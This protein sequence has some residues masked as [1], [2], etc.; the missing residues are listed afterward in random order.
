M[1]RR[2]SVFIIFL[3]FPPLVQGAGE[4]KVDPQTGQV[5]VLFMGDALMEAGFVTPMLMQDP[6]LR[7][8]PIP[9]EFLTGLY[10][11]IEDAARGLRQYFPRVERQVKPYD[12]TWM[13]SL[14]FL[15]SPSAP[16]LARQGNRQPRR[17]AREPGPRGIRLDGRSVL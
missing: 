6:M 17:R 7:V 11:S 15:F 12:A 16:R 13:L 2:I 9:V 14:D 1:N 10:A 5:R 3:L 4:P 8:S